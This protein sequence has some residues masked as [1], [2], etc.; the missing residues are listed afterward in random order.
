QQ[1]V[2]LAGI[3]PNVFGDNGAL[4]LSGTSR[5][6]AFAAL[7][8]GGAVIVPASLAARQDI[9]VGEVL[10]IGLPGLDTLPFTV[11]GVVDFSL[12]ARTPDGALLISL[13]DARDL[14]GATTAALWAMVP[15]PGVPPSSFRAAVRD[16]AA[17][18]AGEA[19]TAQ[20][21]ADDL[22]RGLDRLIGL[23]DALALVAVVIGALGVVNTLSIGVSERV[24]EIAVLRSNGMTV[25]QVQAMV[26][27]EAAIMGAMGGVLAVGIGLA[28]AWALVN[29]GAASGL[30]GGLELPWSLLIAVV[31]VGT[32]VA[33]LAGLYP[34]RVA[35][36]LPI[37]RHLTQFE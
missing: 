28:V 10:E 2:S 33:A 27:S 7:R 9:A 22:S 11:A 13:A 25:G 21:L 36:A 29:A 16:T 30:S 4:R 23:F 34:A 15:Q 24:R 8:E 31:L 3:D 14:F 37:M 35:G 1:E 17:Q 18:L 32:G 20:E 5:I 19:L 26:V 6:A 12:P